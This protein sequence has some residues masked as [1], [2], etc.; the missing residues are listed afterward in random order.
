MTVS[1]TLGDTQQ[2]ETEFFYNGSSVPTV[3]DIKPNVL[4]VEGGESVNVTYL[5]FDSDF[6]NIKVEIGEH[7]VSISSVGENEFSFISPPMEP[8]VYNLNVLI[9][10]KGNAKIAAVVEYKLFVTSF[11]PKLGSIKGEFNQS[12]ILMRYF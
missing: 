4:S 6:S 7:L 9:S 5:N 11:T 10:D 3:T 12:I 8:G 1:D 2:F